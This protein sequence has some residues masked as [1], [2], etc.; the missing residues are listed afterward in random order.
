LLLV[1][2]LGPVSGWSGCHGCVRLWATQQKQ[3]PKS[4]TG[5][6]GGAWGADRMASQRLLPTAS[7]PFCAVGQFSHYLLPHPLPPHLFFN[8]T[9]R[10]KFWL[11][12]NRI[13]TTDFNMARISSKPSMPH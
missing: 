6:Q 2:A 12:V 1:E 13:F 8:L 7:S 5:E 3:G 10:M 9:Q 11:N 4:L